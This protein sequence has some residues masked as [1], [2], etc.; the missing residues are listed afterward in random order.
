MNPIE[1]LFEIYTEAQ[2]ASDKVIPSRDD[3][4]PDVLK[5]VLGWVFV[6]D[7][8]APDQM[9]T[10]LSG[11]HI[12]YVLRR[13]MTGLNCFDHCRDSDKAAYQEFY[14][15][16][17]EHPCA[18]YTRRRVALCNGEVQGY[19]SIYLPVMGA[20]GRPQIIGAVV[21][22]LEGR[23]EKCHNVLNMPEFLLTETK[24]VFDIGAGEPRCHGLSLIDLSA[25]LTEMERYESIPLDPDYREQRDYITEPPRYSNA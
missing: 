23:M 10:R 13:N 7:W 6:A 22:V 25:E 19:F 14:T 1:R 4:P 2:E 20:D 3:I 9:V 8:T 17:T 15:A 18:G 12:D 24:G 16:I 21:A 11:I 5:D